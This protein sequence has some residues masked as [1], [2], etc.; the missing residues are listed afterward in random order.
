MDHV[1]D[2]IARIGM[3][4]LLILGGFAFA[5]VLFLQWF[6]KA[7][8]PTYTARA[9]C[10]CGWMGMTSRLKPR[11]PQCGARLDHREA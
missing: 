9:R 7:E 11:C 5:G 4:R 8:T 2:I 6:G 10:D 3:N 1:Q